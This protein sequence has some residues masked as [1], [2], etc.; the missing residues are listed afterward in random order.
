M[1]AGHP[2][3]GPPEQV[4]ERPEQVEEQ[5]GA[6]T[7]I[8]ELGHALGMTPAEVAALGLSPAEIRSLLSGF[9]EETVVVG[10][11][12]R[13]RSAT[14]SAVPVDVLSATDLL[15]R[16]AGDLKDQLRTVIPS[17]NA[18]TQP[19]QGA[20]TVV[21]PAML[22]NLAP[23]H[24]LV[25]INGKRRHR[26]SVLEWHGGNGVAYGSQGPDIS[27]IPA[28]ALRQ[29]EVLRDGAAA[30]Y[31]SDAI[32]GVMNFQLKDAASGGAV[33]VNT[34]VYGAG[35]GEGYQFAGNIGLPLGA[36]GFTN[37]S[38][39]YGSS[40]QT[41]RTAPRADA[42]ALI[43][44]GNTHVRSEHPQVW[45]DPDIDDDLKIF[46]N[47]GY[48]L[49]N[50]VQLYAHTNYASKKVTQSFFFRNPN[51]RL[52]VFSIDG[53]RTL[54]IGDALAASGMGSA[55]CPTVSVTNHVPDP[56]ALQQVR[57]DPNCFSFQEMFPGGFTPQMGGTA[58]DASLAGG[59]RGVTAGGFNWDLSGS[60]GM[61]GSDLFIYDTVNASL[62]PA[63]PTSFD[64]GSNR[65][66]ELNL[67]FDVSYAV[68]DRVNLA[69]GAEW[70]DE[71][72]RTVEGDRAGWLVGPYAEQRFM[73]GANGFFGYG[74]RHA[75]TWSRYNVA[76]YGDL[77]VTGAENAWTLGGAVRVE[78][79][80]DF[81]TTTNGKLSGRFGFVR[82]A[83]APGSGRR[84][85]ASR[86]GS[87]SRAGSTR[88]SAT[89]ST[90]PSFRP[91]QRWRNSAADCRSGRSSRSTTPPASSSTPAPS[92]SRPT[93]SASTSPNGSGSRATSS[94][95][96]GRSPI[97][98][99]AGSTPRRACGTSASSPT[100]L[101]R[102]RRA[103]TSF[104]PSRRSRSAATPS[105]APSSTTPTPG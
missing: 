92:R 74:P 59:V 104:R 68:T 48:A 18:N 32:A 46:G 101:P 22:R 41:D 40:N 80:E 99:R 15:G 83:S 70:R 62:G 53:G 21:R 88:P 1:P 61:H 97:W 71:Q 73:A 78:N 65:Q 82:G 52:G 12:A 28:I 67:S 58:T 47:F 23:D 57:D 45:G 105:S 91:S 29:V 90:T 55:N 33:E 6:D 38:L 19:I 64:V 102:S 76:A 79:F 56:A 72:F 4:E 103:S 34:G 37:L 17:F 30:Q 89:S 9:T 54:L 36:A 98:W 2:R 100:P 42:V 7:L 13:P 95:R 49:P 51:T 44:A 26:A 16:G 93:T 5:T 24:T 35:D 43:A 85:R 39:E 69:A 84:P 11:R 10:S 27:V 31:G 14:E 81:G 94:S 3:A 20:S 60:V 86:T 77:E 96:T 25:L 8:E 66:R 50:G 87:T 63:S 75:G